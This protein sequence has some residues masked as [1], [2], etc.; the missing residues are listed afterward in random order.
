MKKLLFI[1]NPYAGTRK[2]VK[3]LAEMMHGNRFHAWERV[4]AA[5]CRGEIVGYCTFLETD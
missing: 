3:H 1:M 4:F 2:G 5:V